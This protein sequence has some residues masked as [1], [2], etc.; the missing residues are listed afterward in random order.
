M[1]QKYLPIG[2]VNGVNLMPKLGMIMQQPFCAIFSLG[3]VDKLSDSEL[4]KMI[5]L[6][7]SGVKTE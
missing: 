2:S 7:C 4:D 1:K 3:D 5:D 6:L